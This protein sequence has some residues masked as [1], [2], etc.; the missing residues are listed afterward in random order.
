MMSAITAPRPSLADI[1]KYFLILGATGF[2]GPVAL[3]DY[4]RRDLVQN[5]AWLSE[6]EYKEGLAIATACPGPLAYQLGVYCGFVLK[7]F[8][9]ALVTAISFALAPF[10]IVVALASLYSRFAGSWQ[11]RALFYGIGPVIIAIIVKACWN[12]GVKTIGRNVVA[13]AVAVV[14]CAITVIVKK[15]L[16]V[17]FIAAGVL[18]ILIFTKRAPTTSPSPSPPKT[19]TPASAIPPA[20]FS[21][22]I[23]PSAAM[24]AKLFAFFFKTGFLV[25]GSG[26]VIVPFL[27]T[28]LV[29]QYGWLSQ[30][31]FVD[32]VAIGLMSPGPVVITATFVGYLLSGIA[33]AT[34]ATVGIFMPSILFTVVGTPLLRRYRANPRLQGFV[35]GI[36]VAVVGV[37]VGTSYLVGQSVVVDW[38]TALLALTALGVGLFAKRVPDQVTVAAGAIAG[39]I[40]YPLLHPWLLVK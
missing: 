5:R 2:G 7:G 11:L 13:L 1:A 16:T 22:L 6:E 18:G 15:E 9:G 36:T 28:Y 23:G 39:L 24:P 40:A 37:L 14:A 4:I 31:Q 8:W 34:A 32:A 12:L 19:P 21:A 20:F 17:L 35:V 27:Q 26:L 29:D 30:Q 10:L 33:G 38:L 25:F 3:A